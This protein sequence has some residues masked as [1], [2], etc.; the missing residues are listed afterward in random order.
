MYFRWNNEGIINIYPRNITDE[1]LKQHHH[2]NPIHGR[3]V[4]MASI[5][6]TEKVQ[7]GLNISDCLQV[8]TNY[9]SSAM[10]R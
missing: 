5:A 1:V 10:T 7:R 3:L 9:L 4:Q 6:P 8:A 2:S